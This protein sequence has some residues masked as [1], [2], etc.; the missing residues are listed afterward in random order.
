MLRL[1]VAPLALAVGA[2]MFG[3]MAFSAPSEA[4]VVARVSLSSQQMNVYVDGYHAYSWP[5]STA[6]AGYRTPTGSYRPQALSRF[7]RSSRYHN[8]P[9]PHSVFFQG[10]YAI[11]GSYETGRLGRPASHGCIR[12]SPYHAELLYELIQDHG[13]GSTRIVVQ[14]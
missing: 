6:R 2:I 9:M 8:A 1:R 7:H 10:G 12:L 11:H 14:R 13:A 3:L 5:V 4:R